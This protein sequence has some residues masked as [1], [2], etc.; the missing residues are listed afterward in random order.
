MDKEK[1]VTPQSTDIL[2][3]RTI[4]DLCGIGFRI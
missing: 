4:D 2:C 3:L 1:A